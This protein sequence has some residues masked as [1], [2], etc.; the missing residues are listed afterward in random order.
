[1]QYVCNTCARFHGNNG[2][3]KFRTTENAVKMIDERTGTNECSYLLRATGFSLPPRGILSVVYHR[4][5]INIYPLARE[6]RRGNFAPDA[7]FKRFLL[8]TELKLYTRGS[9]NWE[10]FDIQRRVDNYPIER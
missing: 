10:I 4:L 2:S 5:A 6:M 1:M 7:S 3:S 9:C 8:P